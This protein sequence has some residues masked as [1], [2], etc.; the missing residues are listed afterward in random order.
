MAINELSP[1]SVTSATG[2]VTITGSNFDISGNSL[3]VI[4]E[5]SLSGEITSVTPTSTTADE[6]TFDVPSVQAGIY[7]VRTRIDPNGES[8]S[9]VLTIK[10]SLSSS[11]LS[12][13]TKGGDLP[14]AG[15]GLPSEWPSSLFSITMVSNSIAME[16]EVVSTSSTELKIKIPEGENSQVYTITILDPN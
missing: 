5:N 15:K 4:L 6:V 16:V 13:S 7:K 14:I 8:N 10:S 3:A 12:F 2:S 11:T 1:T 9:A